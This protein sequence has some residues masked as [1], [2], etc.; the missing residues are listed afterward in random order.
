MRGSNDLG[1]LGYGTPGA[2]GDDEAPSSVA[3]LRFEKPVTQ[4]ALG[5]DHSCALTSSG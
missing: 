1:Q 3:P 5:F 4:L 2:I